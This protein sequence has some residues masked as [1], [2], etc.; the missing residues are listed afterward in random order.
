MSIIKSIYDKTVGNFKK[1]MDL[2]KKDN[3]E[4]LKRVSKMGIPDAETRRKKT[5]EE[6]QKIKKSRESI[7]V[8][9]PIVRDSPRMRKNYVRAKVSNL[10]RAG[11]ASNI[12]E[13]SIE[14]RTKNGWYNTMQ[15]I[16]D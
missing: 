13:G 3:Q 5:L 6:I 15:R 11:K 2:A 16:E 1:G 4:A 7:K 12:A 8:S 9:P 14:K 10:M